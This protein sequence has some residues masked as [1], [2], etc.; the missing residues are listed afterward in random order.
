VTVTSVISW[1]WESHFKILYRKLST[2]RVSKSSVIRDIVSLL[3]RFEFGTKESLKVK[4][5]L[6]YRRRHVGGLQNGGG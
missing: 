5:L 1:R 2:L 4:E 3:L 6:V